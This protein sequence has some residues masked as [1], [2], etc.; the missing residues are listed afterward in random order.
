MDKTI[1]EAVNQLK[2]HY[3]ETKEYVKDSLLYSDY[4]NE[5]IYHSMQVVGA[6]KYII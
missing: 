3:A 5:K 1:E 2:K 6:M 4:A